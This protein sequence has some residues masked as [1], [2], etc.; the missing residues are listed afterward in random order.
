MSRDSSFDNVDGEVCDWRYSLSASDYE[1]SRG[2]GRVIMDV[3]Y[4]NKLKLASEVI[5]IQEKVTPLGYMPTTQEM[6]NYKDA[7]EI[8]PLLRQLG[9][10]GQGEDISS[11]KTR[12]VAVQDGDIRIEGNVPIILNSEL[13]A[14]INKDNMRINSYDNETAEE[15]VESYDPN[16]PLHEQFTTIKEFAVPV[17][18]TKKELKKSTASNFSAPKTPESLNSTS[19]TSE[20]ISSLSSS[21]CDD[22]SSSSNNSMLTTESGSDEDSNDEMFQPLLEAKQ[23]LYTPR[24]LYELKKLH[25]KQSLSKG[26]SHHPLVETQS[27]PISLESCKTVK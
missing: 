14:M 5:G 6:L 18:Q 25:L 19:T 1:R 9:I 21:V 4:I 3:N 12:K 7:N 20:T 24:Q 13:F 11:R 23:K 2:R 17:K 26:Y 15:D 22:S 27:Q 8:T 16:L 10:S